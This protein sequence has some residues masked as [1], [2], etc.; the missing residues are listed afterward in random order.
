MQKKVFSLLYLFETK[1]EPSSG[2][3]YSLKK[4]KDNNFFNLLGNLFL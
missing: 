4:T 1:E 3:L 2:L